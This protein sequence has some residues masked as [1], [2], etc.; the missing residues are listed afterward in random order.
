MRLNALRKT[1]TEKSTL[2]PSFANV[3]A[4]YHLITDANWEIL[5]DFKKHM[6]EAVEEKQQIVEHLI[7]S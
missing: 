3:P 2:P 5:Q 6:A 4:G 7:S 1:S